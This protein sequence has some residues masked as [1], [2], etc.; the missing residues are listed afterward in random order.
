MRAR[1]EGTASVRGA[2]PDYQEAIDYLYRFVEH[3]GHGRWA[4]YERA[5]ARVRAFLDMLGHPE[6][7]FRS[8]VVAGTKGKGSTAVLL[9]ST[10]RAAGHRVGLYTSPHL[11]SFRERIQVQRQLISREQFVH[12]VGVLRPLVDSWVA[13]HPRDNW[14]TTFE[15]ATVM[16]ALHFAEEGVEVAVLEVG[17]GGRY[18]AVNALP[19]QLALMTTISLDHVDVLGGTLE[20]IAREKA[21]VIPQEGV[22]VSGEQAPEVQQVLQETAQE[23]QAALWRAGKRGLEVWDWRRGNPLAGQVA[24]PVAP[25]TLHLSLG[26]AFQQRNLRVAL[27]GVAA[28]RDLGWRLPTEAVTKG[29]EAATWPGRFEVVHCPPPTLVDGAH[30]A[31]SARCLVEALAQAYP[32]RPIIWVAGFSSGKDVAGVL[33]ALRVGGEVLVATRSWHPRALPAGDVAA[34]ARQVFPRVVEAEDVRA[35]WETARQAAADQAVVCFTGSLFVVAE[36][37][38]L[39][40]L[41]EEMD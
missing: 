11:H 32:G 4:G 1:T 19:H 2:P 24:Y 12:W 17:R 20:A 38:E 33:A 13:T 39:F 5:P 9:E 40:G 37:R 7:T 16:A 23:R 36:A 35:A 8:I 14:P 29:M 21:G 28:L 15:L 27:G 41:A 31:D 10:L 26:G 6:R 18:D 30:N 22:L 34:A 3:T 25:A